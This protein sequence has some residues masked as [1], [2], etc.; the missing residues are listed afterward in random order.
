MIASS[1]PMGYQ[2]SPASGLETGNRLRQ[3]GTSGNSAKR[4]AEATAISLIKPDR[5]A[6][7]TPE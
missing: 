5:A 7:A 2:D 3:V 4:L 6:P 1:V